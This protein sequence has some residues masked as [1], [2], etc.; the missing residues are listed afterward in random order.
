[1][2]GLLLNTEPAY[3]LAW[4]KAAANFGVMLDDTFLHT[5]FGQHADAVENA[6]RLKIGARFDRQR[7]LELAG[8]YWHAQVD[9]EGIRLMPGAM[10]TV[11]L[12]R[13]SGIPFAL[14]T[15]SDSVFADK[16]LERAGII[17]PFSVRVCRNEVARG[18]PAPDLFIE[19]AKRLAVPISHA[20]VLEDSETGLLAA[21][22][23]G[24]LPIL[25]NSR[26]VSEPLRS[27]AL[28]TFSSL[29]EVR[30]AILAQQS[31]VA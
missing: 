29:H 17:G 3:A 16:C 22:Q 9:A 23:A 5:L 15:N 19:A 11:D 6:M 12:F 13:E 27:L 7:F 14:A 4:K 31:P 18:K 2:D 24:A 1:M 8:Q 21:G 10:E 20:L 26:P 25:V 28:A 30:T